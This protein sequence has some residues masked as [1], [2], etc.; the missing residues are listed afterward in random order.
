M[1]WQH[2]IDTSMAL[3]E[4]FIQAQNAMRNTKDATQ[5]AKVAATAKH[6][7][8]MMDMHNKPSKDSCTIKFVHRVQQKVVPA[9]Q[10]M[11]KMYL[12]RQGLP[13]IMHL[14]SP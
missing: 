3:V 13:A 1:E 5:S 10:G 14:P 11:C 7:R 2:P 9:I 6:W 12:S 4:H 8:G